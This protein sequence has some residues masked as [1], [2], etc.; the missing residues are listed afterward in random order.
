MKPFSRLTPAYSMI[1]LIWVIVILGI[2]ASIS[3]EMIANV[4]R[5]YVL[6]RAQERAETKTALA[7]TQIANRIRRAIPGTV[8]RRSDKSAGATYIE[9]INELRAGNS[10]DY[11]V[12]QWVGADIDSFESIKSGGNRLPGWSGFCDLN[13]STASTIATPGSNLILADTIIKN[14]GGTGT[15]GIA[16]AAIYFPNDTT[17]HNVSAGSG[18]TLTLED[19][20][21]TISEHYK[22]AWSSYALVV[23]NNDLY[24]YYNRPPSPHSAIT[25]TDNRA[26]LLRNISTFKFRGDGQVIRFKICKSERIANDV[27]ITACKEKAVF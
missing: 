22:L 9:N 10:T 20:A 25:G 14:L 19:N 17:E 5:S 15:N 23:E 11:T 7:A 1:E 13:A 27:N 26:I 16:D 4:Y 18:T 8:Y 24:L 3:S 21:S 12:L 6:Q 2:V